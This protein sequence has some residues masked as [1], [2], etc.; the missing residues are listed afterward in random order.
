M[1]FVVILQVFFS[2]NLLTAWEVCIF[3]T[4]SYR[5]NQGW[6]K[7]INAQD[8][9]SNQVGEQKQKVGENNL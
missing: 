1:V 8:L 7:L 5:R 2:L 3:I 4:I 9:F 6:G